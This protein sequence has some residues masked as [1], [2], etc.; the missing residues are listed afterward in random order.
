[1]CL[2]KGISFTAIY[3]Q[4]LFKVKMLKTVQKEEEYLAATSLIGE[5]EFLLNAVKETLQ[6]MVGSLYKAKSKVEEISN[7]N[8]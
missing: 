3:A 7:V 4:C 2:F 1:M 6:Q 5:N 8:P